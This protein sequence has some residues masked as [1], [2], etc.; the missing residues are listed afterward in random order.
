MTSPIPALPPDLG[1]SPKGIILSTGNITRHANAMRKQ[2]RLKWED[3][4][5][6]RKVRR[7]LVA[8]YGAL[9]LGMTAVLYRFRA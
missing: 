8:E 2:K 4:E 1:L 6:P 7:F 3:E 5:K 9:G